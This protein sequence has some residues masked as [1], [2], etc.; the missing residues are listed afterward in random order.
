MC[1]IN[2]SNGF[3]LFSHFLVSDLFF[4][5]EGNWMLLIPAYSP[6]PV[7]VYLPLSLKR[8]LSLSVM[9]PNTV[10]PGR[11]AALWTWIEHLHRTKKKIKKEDLQ[12]VSD[13]MLRCL[14]LKFTV[15]VIRWFFPAGG[16]N[17]RLSPRHHK[18][19]RRPRNLGRASSDVAPVFT[20]TCEWHIWGKCNERIES[21]L[22]K[23]WGEKNVKIT[24]QT[25]LQ[26]MWRRMHE[27]VL[28]IWT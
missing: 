4:K 27:T 14:R 11:E 13:K 8:S 9:P 3:P 2:F 15:S 6:R 26:D 1:P 7:P 20:Q 25:P 19:N 16:S 10:T 12:L 23:V 22:G 21:D 24:K 5:K 28:Y 18:Q 17:G